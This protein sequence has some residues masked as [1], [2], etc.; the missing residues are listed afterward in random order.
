[1]C[2]GAD[3]AV[4]IYEQQRFEVDVKAWEE[5]A[6]VPYVDDRNEKDVFVNNLNT[7]FEMLVDMDDLTKE[8][9][10]WDSPES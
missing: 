9:V 3:S 8:Q 6:G 4:G 2:Y 1:M 10:F 7:S 5:A